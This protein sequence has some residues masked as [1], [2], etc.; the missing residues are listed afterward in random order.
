M[1]SV[2]D[3]RRLVNENCLAGR[4]VLLPLI[5][6]CGS[7]LAE[8][9]HS[10]IDT[11]PFDQSSMDGYA[12]FIENWNGHDALTIAGEIQAGSS[13]DR[14]LKPAEAFRI[15]T[16]APVPAGADTVVMQEKVII[17]N[18][19]ITI[20][21]K[22]ICKGA[23]VRPK[24]SQTRKGDVA[25]ESNQ[26]LTPAALSFL[27]GMG[28][29][30]VTVFAKPVV[31]LIITGKELVSDNNYLE[32]GKVFESNSISL[33]AALHQLNIIPASVVFTDDNEAEIIDAVNAVCDSDIII[34]SG[35]V[36][37]GDYDLV[38]SA[39]EKCGV[40]KI[41]HHVK[42]KPGKPLYFGKI[43]DTLVFAL[44]GNPASALTCFYEYVVP[45]IAI[46]TQADYMRHVQLPLLNDVS[47]KP[48][49]THFLKGKTSINGVTILGNQESYKLN[50]FSVA[51][52][53]VE[54]EEERDEYLTGEIVKVRMII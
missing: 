30:E 23:N 50:S 42:Q 18:N 35:G 9:L 32:E 43:N 13:T 7:V 8:T 37:V 52:C 27:S 39:L 31:S 48:G 21:D 17:E 16:G 6:A 11:P 20:T 15:Y 28:I 40:R 51:D 54:L 14:T 41:F 24:G 26:L 19:R 46:F 53:L 34:L 49:L 38:P 10:P 33:A 44:P 22:S 1:I 45:S 12:F 47:K 3:A 36:S 25:L 5:K 2:S 29:R 4:K